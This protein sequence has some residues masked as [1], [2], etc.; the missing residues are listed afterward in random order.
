ME[1]AGTALVLAL[2][3]LPVLPDTARGLG[4]DIAEDVRVARDKLGVYSARGRFDVTRAALLEQQCQEVLLEQQVA[5]LVEQLGVIARKCGVGD[6]VRLLNGVRNDRLG[7][8]LAI[9]RALAAQPLGQFLQL[10]EGLTHR[11]HG[12]TKW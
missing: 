7:R 11:A 8:L 12:Q 3:P 10:D 9:P 2:D 1:D 6:L 4:F 5:D